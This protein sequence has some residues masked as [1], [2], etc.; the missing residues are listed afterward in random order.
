[1]TI[2]ALLF[3]LAWKSSIIVLAA[4]LAVGV[5]RSSPAADKVAILRLSVLSLFFLPLIGAAVPH[6]RVEVPAPMAAL[7]GGM[8]PNA[9]DSGLLPS[10]ALIGNMSIVDIGLT[11]LAILLYLAGATILSVRLCGGVITLWRWTRAATPVEDRRWLDVLVREASAIGVAPPRLLVSRKSPTPLSWGVFRPVILIDEA[12]LGRPG[13][14]PAILA[15]EL[16]HVSHLDWVALVVMRVSIIPFWFNPLAWLLARKLEDETEK[17]ADRRAASI[18]GTS[19]YAQTLVNYAV[20]TLKSRVPALTMASSRRRLTQ[21][22]HALIEDCGRAPAGRATRIAMTLVATGL[23][24]P[25]AT[26]AVFAATLNGEGSVP[27][28]DMYPFL[29]LFYDL[30]PTDRSKLAVSYALTVNG[31]P[32]KGMRF[33]L[34]VNGRRTP[35][36][37]SAN[38]TLERMPTPAEMAADAQVV[39]TGAVG[40]HKLDIGPS[41]RTSIAPAREIRAA[42]CDL[43]LAQVNS[44]GGKL[45]RLLSVFIPKVKAV[46]FPG[47]VDGVAM[48]ADGSVVALPKIK[49]APAYMPATIH[50]A[51]LIRLARPPTIVD[52]E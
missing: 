44:A 2:F 28:G 47:A 36:P 51:R 38:G 40:Q 46:T 32:P 8:I 43:A 27:A 50:S 12:S 21:R 13:D 5:R 25:V 37:L 16:A 14:A 7:P 45:S 4:I 39:V 6:F 19:E 10:T 1:M 18:L 9:P 17:A 20:R 49:G 42:D 15:H 24:M 33:L 35:I 23:L 52:L 34:D 22:V 48:L 41:L 30:P 31:E 26:V 11:L 29:R 3:D